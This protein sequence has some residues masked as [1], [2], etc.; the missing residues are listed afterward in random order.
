M[1]KLLTRLTNCLENRSSYQVFVLEQVWVLKKIWY[2][3]LSL[4][5]T[6]FNFNTPYVNG[7]SRYKHVVKTVFRVYLS[8]TN[9]TLSWIFCGLY[10]LVGATNWGVPG[11]PF[12]IAT[13]SMTC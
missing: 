8:A 4:L 11:Y 13:I 10:I 6:V 2:R 12:T 5:G 9:I 1:L 3:K 7:N